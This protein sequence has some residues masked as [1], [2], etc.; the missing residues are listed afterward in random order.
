MKEYSLKLTAS[1]LKKYIKT[2]GYSTSLLPIMELS[3]D[4]YIEFL[5][6]FISLNDWEGYNHRLLDWKNFSE[7]LK[8]TLKKSKPHSYN[9]VNIESFTMAANIDSIKVLD[10]SIVVRLI[11]VQNTTTNVIELK[12]FG[13]LIIAAYVAFLFTHELGLSQAS[14][15]IITVKSLDCPIIKGK[16]DSYKINV[17]GSSCELIV[18]DSRIDIMLILNNAFDYICD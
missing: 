16:I 14:I 18:D 8:N 11:R 13:D 2:K 7:Y 5:D 12:T 3:R 9:G 6:R 17:N 15:N 1:E 10:E 4:S